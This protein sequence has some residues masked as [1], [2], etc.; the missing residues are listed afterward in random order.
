MPG[1]RPLDAY[2]RVSQVRGREGDSFISPA[3]QADRIA[4][5]AQRA[6]VPVG[7]VLEELDVSGGKID[8]PLLD[9]AL[10]RIDAGVSGGLI[11]AHMDR[12]S[13][14]LVDGVMVMDRVRKAGG[15]FVAVD[16]GFDTATSDG[17]LQ[18]Q[19]MLAVAQ[20]Q[21]RRIRGNWDE[22]RRRAV[23]RGIHP[24]AAPPF[25]YQHGEDRRLAPDPLERELVE[26]VFAMRAGEQSWGEIRAMLREAGATTRRGNDFSLR[27]LRDIVRSDVY[28]GVARHGTF[29]NREAH[30]AIVDRA[31]WV[32]A[33]RRGH[34]PGPSGHEASVAVGVVRCAGCRYLMRGQ[35]R[36]LAGG[37]VRLDLRCRCS[38]EQMSNRCEQPAAT[39]R[40]VEI[41]ALLVA[42]FLERMDE[43]R[44]SVR[45][46]SAVTGELE[47]EVRR[48]Q[49]VLD[50]LATDPRAQEAMGMTAYLHALDVRRRDVE[51]LERDLDAERRA[52]GAAELVDA[53]LRS[54]WD[55]FTIGERRRLLAASVDAVF[56]RQGGPDVPV[57]QLVTVLWAGEAPEL[58]LPRTGRRDYVPRPY[59]DD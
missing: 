54:M 12:F 27:A 48:A 37:E 34:A 45:S 2:V 41:E 5:W 49:S 3:V 59:D 30:E 20:D 16:I 35:R 42:W 31:V 32:A 15:R 29:E 21:L 28:L 24:C 57:E 14:S 40:G 33:Q 4:A 55:T 22:A 46:R 43:V 56:I 19:I 8:R 10:Q 18:A 1:N 44:A 7:E 38:S 11:V 13:R 51:R 50:A 47:R 26:R 25:G 39:A 6:G 23:E 36:E 53:D 9:R 52:T 58:D 17:E